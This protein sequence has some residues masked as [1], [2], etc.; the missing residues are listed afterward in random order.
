VGESKVAEIE[1]AEIEAD[2]IEIV[3][4]SAVPA[5][6][7]CGITVGAS[8]LCK[9]MERTTCIAASHL[10]MPTAAIIVAMR[11]RLQPLLQEALEEDCPRRCQVVLAGKQEATGGR[12]MHFRALWN[13]QLLSQVWLLLHHPTSD[14]NLTVLKTSMNSQIHLQLRMRVACLSA[15]QAVMLG[16]A[17]L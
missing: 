15:D 16:T 7:V 12:Q 9:I 4:R 2:V 3:L 8:M 1:A 13:N 10:V 17:H 11:L 6:T 14:Q 5:S